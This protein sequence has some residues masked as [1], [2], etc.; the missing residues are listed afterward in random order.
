MSLDEETIPFGPNK[1]RTF[2]EVSLQD[3]DGIVGW[4]EN[5]N[6]HTGKFKDF[7]N[8]LVAYLTENQWYD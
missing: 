3:L 1:H 4:L 8:K 5:K 2:R 7:Y 6:L